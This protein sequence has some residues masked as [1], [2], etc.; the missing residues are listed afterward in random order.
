MNNSYSNP[1]SNSNTGTII[2]STTNF[3]ITM[4]RSFVA[5]LFLFNQ[6]ITGIII[7]ILI[8]LV[9]SGTRSEILDNTTFFETPCISLTED[10][11]FKNKPHSAEIEPCDPSNK[12]DIPSVLSSIL[13][14]SASFDL[15]GNPST[16]ASNWLIPTAIFLN[17]LLIFS[18]YLHFI[19]E[20]LT[21][22]F[23][24]INTRKVE[25]KTKKIVEQVESLDV[26]PGQAAVAIA[27]V[28]RLEQEEFDK[29]NE[30]LQTHVKFD[31][32]QH[33]TQDDSPPPYTGGQQGGDNS[34]FFEN[35]FKLFKYISELVGQ[36]GGDECG[37][38]DALRLFFGMMHIVIIL[39]LGAFLKGDPLDASSG[40]FT[41]FI[42]IVIGFLVLGSNI[43]SGS[44]GSRVIYGLIGLACFVSWML[45]IIFGKG[46]SLLSPSSILS[47]SVFIIGLGS[48]A[49]ASASSTDFTN[50]VKNE[51]CPVNTKMADEFDKKVSEVIKNVKLNPEELLTRANEAADA[52]HLA[53]AAAWESEH[54]G[55]APP[56]QQ[57]QQQEGG[58]NKESIACLFFNY[59]SNLSNS[60]ALGILKIFIIAIGILFTPNYHNGKLKDILQGLYKVQLIIF[61]VISCLFLMIFD[62]IPLTHYLSQ[63]VK[64][65]KEG[66]LSQEDLSKGE[67][68][69]GNVSKISFFEWCDFNPNP[70][71]SECRPP[72]REL[73]G[74]RVISL[75]NK[76]ALKDLLYSTESSGV[77]TEA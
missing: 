57:K 76:A 62:F 42:A 23:I 48:F 43:P 60:L 39:I 4:T 36:L 2:T 49:L 18:P 68:L 52:K 22:I 75:W 31:N 15:S 71:V 54:R 27:E 73:E 29:L 37:S 14:G 72:G 45:L 77:K 65:G 30:G 7:V 56:P 32:P 33:G 24:R 8:Y 11:G 51:S 5:T 69:Y 44:M 25:D 38:G 35:A 19:P 55:K 26:T 9:S 3:S 41:L 67:G 6:A 70:S 46:K 47:A 1:N 20:F 28:S 21:K 34:A 10:T 74:E 13:N 63:L 16:T 53:I 64:T 58:G 50:T 12:T 40:L 61:S 59:F 66:K 17:L